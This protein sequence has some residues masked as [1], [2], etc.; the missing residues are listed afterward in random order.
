MLP[1][2]DAVVRMLHLN[3]PPAANGRS[4]AA[5]T[6]EEE[7]YKVLVL[8]AFTKDVMAPLLRVNDLRRHGITLHLLLEVL[9]IR[10]NKPHVGAF[11]HGHY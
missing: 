11:K 2:T 3:A 6:S 5:P 4:A 10:M 8:D 9:L 7:Y 1:C